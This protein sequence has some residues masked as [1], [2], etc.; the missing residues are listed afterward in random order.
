M[1][2]QHGIKKPVKTTTDVS[3][4]GSVKIKQDVV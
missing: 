3:G 4:V 1:H 2:L